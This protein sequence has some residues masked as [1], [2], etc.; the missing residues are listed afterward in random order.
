MPFRP[1]GSVWGKWDLHFHT[2]SSYDY[3]NKSVT[4]RQIIEGLL[5][6]NV[7]AV[8]VTDHHLIDAARIR[9]L[10]SLGAGKVTVFPG[11]ELRSEL[12]GKES[13]HLIGI[14]SETAN[15]EHIWT[16]MQGPLNLTV[17]EVQKE[18]DDRV[19]VRFEEAAKLIHELGGVVSVHVGRKANSIER[20]GNDHP[21]K[22]AFKED[23]ARKHIDLFEIGRPPDVSSYR[24]TVFPEIGLERP[25]VICSDNHDIG[26]YVEKGNCWIKSD[27]AFAG[28]QQIISD[29]QERVYI[30]E[31]PPSVDRVRRHATKYITSISFE[32]IEN[33]SLSEHWFSGTV[34]LNPGLIAVI[35]NKGTGKTA[36]VEG[37]GLTGENCS[38]H[39]FLLPQRR[40]VSAA[41]EQ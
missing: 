31:V 28:F 9:S 21:Y 19:Y 14:F 20:I 8:A 34:P 27:P 37:I 23:L 29:P 30:G 41:E 10:Q 39:S 33:S 24:E 3:K 25:L 12:G 5:R 7:A 40:K 26:N 1:I 16:K 22:R 18:G 6:A 2:P 17:T 11:I 35:G 4:D 15:P 36:L 32:K 13:V 38:A